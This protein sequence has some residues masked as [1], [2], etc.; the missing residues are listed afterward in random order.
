MS[1]ISVSNNVTF[2]IHGFSSSYQQL[3]FTKYTQWKPKETFI[4]HFI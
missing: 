2:L 3:H 4:M 1:K